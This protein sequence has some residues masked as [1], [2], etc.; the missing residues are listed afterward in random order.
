MIDKLK[1]VKF[2]NEKYPETLKNIS[3]P[4]EQLYVL[5]NIE[6]LKLDGIA[7]IGSRS[8]SDRGKEIAYEY[9]YKL[10][11]LGFTIIS[12]MAKGIDAEAHIGALD[13]GG[14]TIAV[15]GGGFNHIFPKEN[16]E[17]F[18]RI[19]ENNGTVISEYNPSTYYSSKRFIERNRIVSGLSK[20]VLVVEAKYR[21]GTSI[22]ADFAKRQ[23]KEVFCIAHSL[24][25]NTGEG[26]NRLI[27][28]GAHLVTELSDITDVFGYQESIN[29]EIHKPKKNVPEEYLKIYKCI[30]ENIN[31]VNEIIKKL[32]INITEV[33]YKLTMME[34]ENL[35]LKDN[36]KFYIK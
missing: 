35:I 4:P 28:N 15:L 20:G 16:A 33:N 18:K 2:E 10:S 31:T 30:E 25:D 17:L 3:N 13:A 12:G 9:A 27:K 34:L 23:E 24:D 36:G 5:G 22:T 29:T 11:K 6:N 7:I 21:S 32:K 14:K 1:I 8:C 19:I 26:T